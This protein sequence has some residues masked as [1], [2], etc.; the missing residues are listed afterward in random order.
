[1]EEPVEMKPSGGNSSGSR[2]V[3]AKLKLDCSFCGDL[4]SPY[5]LPRLCFVG[6]RGVLWLFFFPCDP[7]NSVI[8]NLPSP[9]GFSRTQSNMWLLSTTCMG[10]Y[11]AHLNF[12]F[13]FNFEVIVESQEVAKLCTRKS[14][15]PSPWFMLS[16]S[17]LTPYTTVVQCANQKSSIGSNPRTYSDF[18]NSTNT[19]VCVGGAVITL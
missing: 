10:L 15:V 1:M 17:G 4:L 9:I 13:F 6:R 2:T 14:H 19:C 16:P 3:R 7:V 5:L 8:N 12:S 18:T 11:G